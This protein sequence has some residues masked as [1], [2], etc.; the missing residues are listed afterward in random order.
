MVATF[1]G[2]LALRA[3]QLAR[4]LVSLRHAPDESAQKGSRTSFALDHHGAG[5][6][7]EVL[8]IALRR[9]LEWADDFWRVG[10]LPSAM[11]AI[12]DATAIDAELR[13]DN[14]MAR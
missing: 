5:S 14:H 13:V 9:Q 3:T 2:A 12:V 11:T 7:F 6:G 1:I 8:Q 10:D 4:R